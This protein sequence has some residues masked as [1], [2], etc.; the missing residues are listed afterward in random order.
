MVGMDKNEINLVRASGQRLYPWRYSRQVLS[1]THAWGQGRG[2][3]REGRGDL[4]A[5]SHAPAVVP[6][7]PGWGCC[8]LLHLF[9]LL[10]YAESL[11][12]RGLHLKGSQ[13]LSRKW[14]HCPHQGKALCLCDLLPLPESRHFGDA[15]GSQ[16][17]HCDPFPT[18]VPSLRVFGSPSPVAQERPAGTLHPGSF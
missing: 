17:R 11:L 7:G 16:C 5:L 4:G 14:Y 9:T 10:L 18:S 1:D 8:I 13:S 3:G 15:R 2:R 6:R 12:R